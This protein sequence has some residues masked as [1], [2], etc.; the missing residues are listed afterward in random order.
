MPLTPLHPTA[1]HTLAHARHPRRLRFALALAWA[2]LAAG[3]LYAAG[4]EGSTPTITY[5]VKPGDTVQTLSRTLL[6]DPAQFLDVARFNHLRNAN[7]IYP[8]Q[9][10]HIPV[11]L[12]RGTA[13]ALTLSVASGNVK[14]NGQPAT[15]GMAVPEG[16]TVTTGTD[17]SAV[18][19]RSDGTRMQLLPGSLA[20]VKKNRAIEKEKGWFRSVIALVS[21]AMDMAVE[22][23]ALKDH[24]KVTT[25]T[26]TIGV[27]GTQYRVGAASKT[28]RVEV[29][30]GRVATASP[31]A[32][33]ELDLNGGFGTVVPQGKPPAGAIALLPAPR[34]PEGE[35]D[36]HRQGEAF[37]FDAVP[38]AV[39]YRYLV[40]P[41]DQ[42]GAV[43]ATAV[44][45]QPRITLPELRDG[46]YALRVR[47]LDR[48]GL[49]GFDG[50]RSVKMSLRTTPFDLGL[51]PRSDGVRLFWEGGQA[52]PRY[53]V[54]VARDAAFKMVVTE[55]VVTEPQALL[56]D[57][58]SGRYY[59]RVGQERPGQPGDWA[60]SRSDTLVQ[61]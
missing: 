38:G 57:L 24:V 61:P 34:L 22:K 31:A 21:G 40:S 58:P 6:D 46:S 32:H 18:L 60:Y 26:S 15:A 30:L 43:L 54:Q 37:S 7:L 51:Q 1:A 11:V 14:V 10:L 8:G 27:R 47:A 2:C 55:A 59:W 56:R 33:A 9:Q 3:P 23:L 17:S 52:A 42:P 28:S 44:V 35:F 48:N 29:L 53:K 36:T 50:Q 5:T 4:N 45:P 12:L 39:S 16:A 25:P 19:T 20:E 49:E 41:A 13:T